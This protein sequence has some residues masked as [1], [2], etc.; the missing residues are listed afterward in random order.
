MAA[1]LFVS[2]LPA[3]TFAEETGTIVGGWQ[4][5]PDAKAVK[6]PTNVQKAFNE[7]YKGLKESDI[8]SVKMIKDAIPMA[9]YSNQVAGGMNYGIICKVTLNLMTT[10]AQL[11]NVVIYD[12]ADS[13]QKATVTGFNVISLGAYSTASNTALTDTDEPLAGAWA[14][15]DD[16]TKGD[17]PTDAKLIFEKAL[18]N[19]KIDGVSF[20]PTAF[21]GSQIVSG[22]NL[23]Y[24][25]QRKPVVANPGTGSTVLVFVYADANNENVEITNIYTLNPDPSALIDSQMKASAKKVTASAKTLKKKNV[26]VKATKAF[27]V[28]NAAGTVTY[29]K[30]KG[31]SKITVAKTGKVTLKKKLKKGTYKV[32][33]SI[34]DAGNTTYAGKTEK[35]T[36]TVKVK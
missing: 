26:T 31:N 17:I 24:L 4:V 33:V 18:A 6:L 2:L 34:K 20:E 16:Y 14:Y 15:A 36:L 9:Y 21:L 23:A 25:C 35:V 10:E 5:A 28:K 1:I 13:S 30:V 22:V 27:S 8:E 7:A 3:T 12:P 19:Y 11:A 29:K 32:T